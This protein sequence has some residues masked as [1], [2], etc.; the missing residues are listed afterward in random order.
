MSEAYK[1]ISEIERTH[2]V[3]LAKKNLRIDGRGFKEFRQFDIETDVIV[4]A[5]GSAY[6]KL[7]NTHIL[8]GVKA[9]TGEPYPDIPNEGSRPPNHGA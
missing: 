2:I 7:G 6:V 4:K 1:V 3:S 5:E 8:A 9:I